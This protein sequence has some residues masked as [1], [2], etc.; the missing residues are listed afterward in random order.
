MFLAPGAE[1]P[2]DHRKVHVGTTG[3]CPS[4]S[5]SWEQ[6]EK[7]K[8]PL[9][10]LPGREIIFV[11]FCIILLFFNPTSGGAECREPGLGCLVC[12][13]EC[14]VEL[15]LLCKEALFW[16]SLVPFCAQ[17]KKKTNQ[18]RARRE[19]AAI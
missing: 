7:V 17:W 2:M 6:Q 18:K 19:L 12:L 5:K 1:G 14:Q 11:F 10:G 8:H 13:C 15:A 3:R 9:W 4:L 16:D